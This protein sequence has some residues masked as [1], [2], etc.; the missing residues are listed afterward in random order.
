[1]GNGF[2]IID[3][4]KLAKPAKV[5]IEKIS[6]AIG[7]IFK[8]YQIRRVA[9]AEA[10]AEK[11]K[12]VA[13]IEITELEQR[14]M[15]RFLAEEAKK[16]SNI[17]NITRIALEDVDEKARPQEMEDDWISNFFDKCRLISDEEMQ[18]LWA[19]VLAG[20]ANTPGKFSKRTVNFLSSIDKSD[21]ILFSKLCGFGMFMGEV[22]PLIFDYNKEIYT[23]N[24]IEYADLKHLDE[25]GLL[26]VIAGLKIPQSRRFKNPFFQKG[27][28]ELGA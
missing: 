12:A 25:I 24:G 13:R 19:K 1:M 9:Q 16:Q 22:V 20:E 3:L 7:G 15:I 5:L 23:S 10:E 27:A 18:S 11:I 2:S 17:E 14:A 4:G 26:T 8:P 21:A 6:D 28:Y